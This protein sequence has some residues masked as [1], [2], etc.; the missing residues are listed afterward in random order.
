MS[1][2]RH[3]PSFASALLRRKAAPTGSKTR[4]IARPPTVAPAAERFDVE[5]Q[6]D[7]SRAPRPLEGPDRHQQR[8]D[9]IAVVPL[10]TCYCGEGFTVTQ[11]APPALVEQAGLLR[12]AC[13]NRGDKG[14]RPRPEGLEWREVRPDG[15]ARR[16]S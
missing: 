9:G 8:D 15:R 4:R 10:Q 1:A 12:Q 2:S 7:P 11:G 13:V 14:S 5:P 6:L 3:K 16:C